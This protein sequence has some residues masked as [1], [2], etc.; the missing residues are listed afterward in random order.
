MINLSRTARVR[1]VVE[2]TRG[3]GLKNVKKNNQKMS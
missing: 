3:T 2:K 1:Y